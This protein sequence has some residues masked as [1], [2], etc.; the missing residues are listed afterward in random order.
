MNRVLQGLADRLKTKKAFLA[1]SFQ[2]LVSEA[3]GREVQAFIGAVFKAVDTNSRR[4]Y[5]LG[6]RLVLQ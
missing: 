4:N 5:K 1:R 2:S 6:L 3:N